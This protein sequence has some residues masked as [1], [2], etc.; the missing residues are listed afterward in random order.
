MA[1]SPHAQATTAQATLQ[2]GNI[3]GPTDIVVNKQQTAKADAST[4][5][6]QALEARQNNCRQ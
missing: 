5:S 3:V 4:I 1:D 2:A 6:E